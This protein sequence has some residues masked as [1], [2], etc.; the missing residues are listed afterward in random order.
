[1]ITSSRL[2]PNPSLANVRD[3]GDLDRGGSSKNKGGGT[4][5]EPIGL[6]EKHPTKATSGIREDQISNP[7]PKHNLASLL[8]LKTKIL[9]IL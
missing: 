4:G 2:D 3:M 1:M 5:T 7:K 9:T 8:E 6:G